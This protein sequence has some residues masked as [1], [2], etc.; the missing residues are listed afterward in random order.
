MH[1]ERYTVAH[2]M[3]KHENKEDTNCEA[4]KFSSV[5]SCHLNS[6]ILD[7]QERNDACRCSHALHEQACHATPSMPYNSIQHAYASL[8]KLTQTT[9]WNFQLHSEFR[10]SMQIF[11]HCEG[12]STGSEAQA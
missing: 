8:I 7:T 6:D 10:Q 4:G 9:N 11:E 1:T 3:A 12:T 2:V 5:T